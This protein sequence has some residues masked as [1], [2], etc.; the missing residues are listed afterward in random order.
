[1]L[2]EISLFK[3]EEVTPVPVSGTCVGH[4][5]SVASALLFCYSAVLIKAL[6]EPVVSAFIAS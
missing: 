1:M 3:E 6:H 2:L 4:A 5:F